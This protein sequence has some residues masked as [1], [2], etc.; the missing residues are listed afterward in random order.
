MQ[1]PVSLPCERKGTRSYIHLPLPQKT[2]PFAS[3]QGN[4]TL[5]FSP[6]EDH[7]SPHSHFPSA[8]LVSVTIKV[9]MSWRHNNPGGNTRPLLQYQSMVPG[10]NRAASQGPAPWDAHLCDHAPSHRNTLGLYCSSPPLETSAPRHSI[11]D[12][13]QEFLVRIHFFFCLGLNRLLKGIA[14]IRN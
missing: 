14:T 6:T 11:W 12:P 1:T 8:S 7:P 10:R 3:L 9:L 4:P 5:F 2:F 13:V